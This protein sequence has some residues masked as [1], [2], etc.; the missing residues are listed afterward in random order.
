MTAVVIPVQTGIQLF[1]DLLDSRFRGNDKVE[2]FF[3]GLDCIHALHRRLDRHLISDIANQIFTLCGNMP[4]VGVSTEKE[5]I[6]K[7]A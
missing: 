5:R 4:D 6:R 2:A 1:H 7:P 3:K